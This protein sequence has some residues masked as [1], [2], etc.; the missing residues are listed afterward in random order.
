MEWVKVSDRLPK[1]F[2]DVLVIRDDKSVGVG[3]WVVGDYE[4][5]K[6]NGTSASIDFWRV[7]P[8]YWMPLP[9]LPELEK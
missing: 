4:R 9:D 1:N 8:A 5:F 3:S 6:F 2:V 7:K